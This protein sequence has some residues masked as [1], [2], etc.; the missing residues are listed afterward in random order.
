MI[1]RILC[2]ILFNFLL[3]TLARADDVVPNALREDALPSLNCPYVYHSVNVITGDYCENQTDL[4][5]TGPNPFT[6]RRSYSTKDPLSQ[7]WQ[8][9]H[10]NIGFSF[11][12]IEFALI[13]S[14]LV[15]E[16]D[17][18]GRLRE[19]FAGGKDDPSHHL[20]LTY[21]EEM[22]GCLRVNVQSNGGQ[23]ADYSFQ[24]IEGHRLDSPYLLEK[25]ATSSGQSVCYHYSDHPRERKKL[26]TKRE[27]PNGRYLIAEYYDSFINNVGGELVKIS[28]PSRD[29]RIGKTKLLKAPA[30]VDETP[31]ITSRF[32]YSE[33]STEVFNA[34]GHKTIYRYGENKK[35]TA[36]LSFLENESLYRAERFFWNERDELTTKTVEDDSG[37]IYSCQTFDYDLLGNLSR[38]TLYGNLTGTNELAIVLDEK[39]RPLNNGV[40]KYR[41]LFRHSDD[42]RQVLLYKASDNGMRERYI[43]HDTS[44]KLLGKLT[45]VEDVLTLRQF[46]QYDSFGNLIFTCLDDGASEDSEDLDRVTER[47]IT[48]FYPKADFPAKGLPETIEERYLDLATGEETLIKSTCLTY[49]ES[50][51]PLTQTISDSKGNLLQSQTF[52]YD[53][54]GRFLSKIDDKGHEKTLSYDENGNIIQLFEDGSETFNTYDFMNRLVRREQKNGEALSEI[55]TYKY[56]LAG[57]RTA[58][59]DLF[60][61]ETT[62]TYDPL[63]RLVATAS[64]AVND[65]CNALIQPIKTQSYDILDRIISSTDENGNT[66]QMSYNS[67]G[68]PLK[69]IHPDGTFEHYEYNLDG[70]LKSFLK[71]D[72]NYIIYDRDFL[73][74]A[75]C[76][77]E[78]SCTGRLLREKVREFSPFHLLKEKDLF[79]NETEIIYDFAGR[80]QKVVQLSGASIKETEITYDEAGRAISR[81]V[82]FGENPEECLVA[83]V[84]Q[85]KNGEATACV[86]ESDR[87]E[88][89]KSREIQAK[90]SE[91]HPSTTYFYDYYNPFGQ[92]VLKTISV[93]ENGFSTVTYHDALR[94]PVLVEKRNI[95]QETLSAKEIH[96]DLK[97]N[98][99]R[100]I[101]S[102][103]DTSKN[104]SPFVLEWSYDS[105]DRVLSSL[106]G[107]L[108]GERRVT[109]YS[110][111][112]SG[113]IESMTKPDGVSLTYEYD[114]AG[115]PIKISSSD[116][117]INYEFAYNSQ[118]LLI[119]AEDKI[120]GT[121]TTR[122]Y[123]E[124]MNLGL[125]VL[126]NGLSL[127]FAFD[128]CKRKTKLCLP[129]AS[130]ITYAYDSVYLR[131]VTRISPRGD[132]LYRHEYKTYSLLGKVVTETLIGNLGS[133]K[134]SYDDNG[135]LLSLET[136]YWSQDL[137]RQGQ[138]RSVRTNDLGGSFE[139]AYAYDPLGQLIEE[140]SDKEVFHYKYDAL[141]N[142]V[143]SKGQIGI[144]DDLGQLASQGNQF[145]SYDLNGNLTRISGPNEDISFAYDALNR[146]IHAEKEKEYAID[147]LY[148]SFNRRILKKEQLWDDATLDWS[149][150]TVTRFLYDGI[151]EIGAANEMGEIE[152]LR[153]LGVGLGAE[154]GAA[155]AIELKG[156]I[157]AP[158]QDYR[159][160]IAC[161]VAMESGLPMEWRRYSAFG[162]SESG[163]LIGIETR[164]PWGFSGK[165]ADKKTGLIFFGARYYATKLGRWITKDPLGIPETINRY[166]YNQNDPINRIDPYGLLSFADI[167]TGMWDAIDTVFG[168]ASR[169]F[170]ALINKVSCDELLRPAFEHIVE[171]I[172]GKSFL[173]LCGYYQDISQTGVHGNGE[174]NDKVRITLIN[175]ILNARSDYKET[176]NLIS[177]AHGGT[178]I[179]YIFDA[180]GGWG[181]D[182]LKCFMA[183]CGYVSPQ[184]KMVA[185]TWKQM[186]EEMGGIGKGGIIYHYAHSIGSAHTNAALSLM[187]PEEKKMIKIFT[188]GTPMV[189]EDDGLNQVCNYVSLRDGVC[190]LDPIGYFSG[191]LGLNDKVIPVGDWLGMPLVDH[192]ING[193]AYMEMIRLL[194][195]QFI[196]LYLSGQGL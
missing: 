85:G 180:T 50:G 6:L 136:P 32:F 196:S 5:F 25:A 98:K 2:F 165:R 187:S 22:D 105:W 162:E 82:I 107:S 86:L 72:G 155:C 4:R 135:E 159:G 190:L 158:I 175:G 17:D 76:E 124:D 73:G 174:I 24:K 67:R 138:I 11:F 96:Y 7:G 121:S 3:I 112:N 144:I 154:I 172:F 1:K 125:E 133:L 31:I 184:A 30:G 117:T 51:N 60:G 130:Q 110:Y 39:G 93:A 97:G 26:L 157:F 87:G 109:H 89:L 113:K 43:Y 108:N 177:D 15:Y 20:S 9:N 111:T 166:I 123:D 150:P 12:P 100:E 66:T 88:I 134:R 168:F 23:F 64:P 91:V 193:G 191:L 45:Y 10:P 118:N 189:I 137:E 70:S 106:E 167:W 74:R 21:I 83:R 68:K 185:E 173:L 18:K 114:L 33:D 47:K 103:L 75:K 48:R 59:V 147:Y 37:V 54:C 101:F 84:L 34:L 141:H 63:G 139:A 153:V 151:N 44:N 69:I 181:W 41:T 188:F 65:G 49:S 28:E 156:E 94:R 128:K 61:H 129:D 53:P 179:H 102:F 56:D 104:R 142:R 116:D 27:E 192:T 55:T 183:K 176:L 42:G 145:Y 148:D 78:F 126:G 13:D 186:I 14:S 8:F 164:C 160:S 36:I 170:S 161:L 195:E 57:N 194:G 146:L 152:E 171:S 19:I 35:L 119:Q 131:S 46:Y 16:F 99:I 79:G 169:T 132:F 40:E 122:S 92:N 127:G 38:Q 90:E 140:S 95:L 115:L 52:T 62:Y 81:K 149:S 163:T 178:N 120:S 29:S 77:K 143:N 71:I 182:M 58:M 80:E